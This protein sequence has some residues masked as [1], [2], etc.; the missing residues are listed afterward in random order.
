MKSKICFSSNSFIRE[1]KSEKTSH[2]QLLQNL[3]TQK[4]LSTMTSWIKW[5]RKERKF[6]FQTSFIHSLDSKYSNMHAWPRERRKGRTYCVI[7]LWIVTR[8]FS[9][10]SWRFNF[11]SSIEH[12]FLLY[13][14]TV[15]WQKK[16]L[17]INSSSNCT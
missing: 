16:N 17:W 15:K 9:F 6:I 12:F 7:T 10:N 11:S 5:E 1:V 13:K 3:H 4:W 14:L 8:K 2:L